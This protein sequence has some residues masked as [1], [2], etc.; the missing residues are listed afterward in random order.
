MHKT[1]ARKLWHETR[2]GRI[3]ILQSDLHQ[4]TEPLVVLGE[5]GM[6]KSHLLEWLALD[7]GYA[8]CTARQLI[9]WP[10]PRTLLGNATALVIDALDEVS[11]QREG[12]AVDLVLRQLGQIDYPRFILSCRVADWRS[13]TGL[14]AIREQ[15]PTA[16]LEL[17]LIPFDDTDAVAF[18]S[19]SIGTKRA[20][21]AVNHFNAQGLY[22]LLGNPQTLDL[23]AKVA[24]SEDLPKTRS[25]LFE[26][27]IEVLRVEHNDAKAERL[28]AKE[29]G[30]DAA[31]AAFAAVILTGGEA[32]ARKSP[33]N[34]AEGDLQLADVASLPGGETVRQMLD[35]RLFKS[36][37]S[38]R[39]SYIHRRVGEYLAARWLAKQA[40]CQRKR[41]RLLSLFHSHELVPTS[42]RGLHAWLALYPAL[43]QD[44][45]SK[46]PV[47]VIEYGEPDDLTVSQARTLLKALETL[48]ADNPMFLGSN[49]S[50]LVRGIAK[51][52]LVEDVRRVITTAGTAFDLQALV[53]EAV[54]GSDIAAA[55]EGDLRAIVLDQQTVFAIRSAAGHALVKSL[56]VRDWSA[57]FRTLNDYGD[58]FSLRLAL[59]LAGEIGYAAIND[60]L[61]VDLV[62]SRAKCIDN[63]VGA[64]WNLKR[65]LPETRIEGVLNRLVKTVTKLGTPL[66]HHSDYAI[67]DLAYHLIAHRAAS[68]DVTAEKLWSW[69]DPFDARVGYDRESRSQLNEIIRQNNHLRQTIQ[70]HVLLAL[71]GDDSPFAR[72]HDLQ[73]RIPNLW[74]TAA[75]I[76]ALLETLEPDNHDDL[77]WRDLVQLAKHDGAEG[78]DVRAA[79]RQFAAHQP[80]LLEWINNLAKPYIPEWQKKQA[81]KERERLAKQAARTAV[82]RKFYS[83]NIDQIRKGD[84]GVTIDLAKAYLKL[85]DDIGDDKPAHERIAQW[86]GS[87]IG[88]AAHEGFEAFLRLEP[89]APSAQDIA[90]AIAEHKQYDAGYIIVCAFAERF[91]NGTGF[92]DLAD[93][94]LMAGLF[95]LRNT[96]L[97]DQAG[98]AGLLEAIEA[99]IQARGIWDSAMRLYHEPQLEARCKSVDGLYA[100]MKDDT[101]AALGTELAAEWLERFPDL[102]AFPEDELIERLIR[103]RR[104]GELRQAAAE[105]ANTSEDDRRCKWEAVGLIVD[106]EQTTNRLKE[107]QIEP[108]LLWSI[109]NLTNDPYESHVLAPLSPAQ[110]EWVVRVFRSSWPLVGHPQSYS[111]NTNPWDASDYLLH[112]IRRLG[113]D[114]REEATATLARLR[115]APTDGYTPTIKAVIAEQTRIHLESTYA[116]P[117]LGAIN[118]ITRDTVPESAADLQAL[119]LEEL[120]IV[121]SKVKSDDAE[122]WRG[123]Y[124]DASIPFEEERC[125]D[126]LLGLLRQGTQEIT[127][128]PEAHVAG[129]KEVDIACSVGSLRIPIEVKGQWHDKLWMGADAQLNTQYTTDWR[130]EG[131][132]IYLVLWFGTLQQKNKQLKSP[133]R[134]I[135]HPETADELREMLTARSKSAGKGDVVVFV[136][137]LVRSSPKKA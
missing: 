36:D 94:R 21:A 67:N 93:E 95:M 51:T 62:I 52:E 33:A 59:E 44:V 7:P 39:F 28:P 125:R 128:N 54:N 35:T 70:R 105:R 87:A 78:S 16:P 20:E 101:H 73:K 117:T 38:D 69:L 63:E 3:E 32:I 98:I 129:D 80:E 74:P 10:D 31:G 137:D 135:K 29:A 19:E 121:Q 107:R 8:R 64:F 92:D 133:G 60:D 131:R 47:G 84:F 68:S 82:N 26:R 61:I 40:D 2:D 127:F 24:G 13:A 136:L 17:H 72:A 66:K 112:L 56:R 79:A 53:L 118:A 11:G 86:L 42:L 57:I 111:G 43:A 18:L 5:A 22:G 119:V 1:I 114:P 116:P 55:L 102:P 30:L 109:R 108:E 113:N 41:R 76:V 104:F 15:Y 6:G 126:H 50:L 124:D 99:T 58:A 14:E 89:P 9:N 34:T 4:R 25:E 106:F 103:S 83:E 27:A 85:F 75:D 77:R 49:R 110:I 37:G 97:D 48:A 71:P 46:D 120:T 81:K 23:I 91:R 123:F 45:I 88:D 90:E 100:F 96:R 65:L 12:D 134:G 130:A 132:G 115:D 122:S